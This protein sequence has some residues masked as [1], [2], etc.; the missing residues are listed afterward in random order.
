M[1]HEVGISKKN[2]CSGISSINAAYVV[3][4]V[5]VAVVVNDFAL[6]KFWLCAS[7][8]VPSCL[9]LALDEHWYHPPR[10]HEMRLRLAM[11]LGKDF[12]RL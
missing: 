12:G 8:T 7:F 4:T 11:A 10:L 2:I 6:G 1:G 5:I 3:K 9:I